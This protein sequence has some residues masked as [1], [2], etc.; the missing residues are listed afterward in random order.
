MMIVQNLEELHEIEK[1]IK[2]HT[3]QEY[4]TEGGTRLNHSEQIIILN[5]KKLEIITKIMT[6]LYTLQNEIQDLKNR[7]QQFELNGIEIFE[8][9]IQDIEYE[10]EIKEKQIKQAIIISEAQNVEN[11]LKLKFGKDFKL[12][13]GQ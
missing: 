10:I 8:K 13:I 1:Q 6:T 12:N 4:C 7:K 9:E 5:E 11:K 2:F 3:Q